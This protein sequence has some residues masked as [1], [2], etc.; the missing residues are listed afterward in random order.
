[1]KYYAKTYTADPKTG[2]LSPGEFLK[3]EQA[4]ALGKDRLAEMVARGVLCAVGGEKTKAQ[5][6]DDEDVTAAVPD[7][8]ADNPNEDTEDGE[9]DAEGEEELMELDGAGAIDAGDEPEEKP[10]KK[11]A[12]NGGGRKQK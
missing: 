6:P 12:K 10:A 3:E 5:E 8:E 11:P 9:D 7:P 1:M 4:A 2:L